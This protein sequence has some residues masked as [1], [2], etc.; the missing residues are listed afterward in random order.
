M[1]EILFHIQRRFVTRAQLKMYLMFLLFRAK[2]QLET[3][4]MENHQSNIFCAIHTHT[5]TRRN[6]DSHELTMGTYKKLFKAMNYKQQRQWDIYRQSPELMRL[7]MSNHLKQ[8]DNHRQS[9]KHCDNS[10]TITKCDKLW[11]ITKGHVI[12]YWQSHKA[13]WQ[14][15]GNHLKQCDNSWHSPKTMW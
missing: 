11:A 9:P 7:F 8:S 4:V 13:M 1:K 14:L 15:M 12:I 5:I 2:F 6:G 10:W 3:Q